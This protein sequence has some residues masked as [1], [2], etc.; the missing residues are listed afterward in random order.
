M[1]ILYIVV[2]SYVRGFPAYLHLHVLYILAFDPLVIQQVYYPNM[3]QIAPKIDHLLC[4]SAYA[5]ITV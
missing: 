5:T 4:S 2:F 1:Y 3:F